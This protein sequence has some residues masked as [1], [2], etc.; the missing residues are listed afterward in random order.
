MALSASASP[1]GILSLDGETLAEA[2]SPTIVLSDDFEA[3]P[4]GWVPRAS[5]SGQGVLATTATEAHGGS[6]AALLTARTSQGDGIG[7]DVTG[8]LVPGTTYELSAW[9]KYAPGQ[10]TDDVWLSMARTVGDSTSYD[11]VAQFTGI[12]DTTWTQVTSRFQM[13]AADSA[14]LYFESAYQGGAAGNTSDLL[15]DDVTI[16]LPR[17]RGPGPHS[18]QGHH[19][20]PWAWRSTAGRPRARPPSSW[21]VISTRSRARTT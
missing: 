18:P 3:G 8:L 16:A 21:C 9:V 20:F 11:T 4:G 6:Q 10:A 13:G 12:S 19:P 2:G 1:A 14:L 7:H 15:L 17:R 5:G